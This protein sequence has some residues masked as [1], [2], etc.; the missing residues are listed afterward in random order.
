MRIL[1]L[2]HALTGGGA[3]RVAA[4]WANGLS[5]RGH[6]VTIMTDLKRPRTYRTLPEVE[7]VQLAQPSLPSNRV[8]AKLWRMLVGPFMAFR[9]FRQ[10]FR[11]RKPDAVIN[12]LYLR[13]YMLLA[14]RA[15][16]SV[17]IPVI[18]TD[19][20]AYE[21]PE[22]CGFGWHQ[23]RNKF[24]DNRFFDRVTVLTRP[25][26]KILSRW[27]INNVEVLHNPLFLKPVQTLPSKEKIVLSVG[28]INQWHVKG[29]DLLMQAWKEVAPR[30][31]D[32]RLRLV[33]Q[34]D[35]AT[36]GKLREF[37]GASSS[38]IDFVPYTPEV[39]AEYRQA[40]IY[41]L[42]SRYEGWGLVMIEA[43]SQGC[44]TVAC[45]YKGRQ[46]EAVTDGENGLLCPVDDVAAIAQ[47][48]NRLIEDDV[49]RAKIQRT[50]FRSV[51]RFDEDR[52]AERIESI[53]KSV[54]RK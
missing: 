43:M 11:E 41:V 49:L 22:G 44:A 14:A 46:A 30:H 48:I 50:A 16:T 15:A 12:V 9:Q 23:W 45:D 34:G 52:V 3:E 18:M 13:H 24:I 1:I 47:R 36:M 10:F 27:G 28:R 19:H 37:A 4:S 54:E 8:L 5:R 32:W 31:P 33:G 40:A 20:N 2:V 35:E 29:F 42:S 26:K 51:A 53:I 17:R 25:D 7:L 21:R 6:E 39:E 38:S